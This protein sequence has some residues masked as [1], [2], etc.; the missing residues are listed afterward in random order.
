MATIPRTWIGKDV[1]RLEDPRLL[2][3]R[4]NYSDDVRLPGMAHAAVLRSPQAHARIVR[5]DTSR[6]RALPGVF[7]VITGDDAKELSNPLPA[8]CAEPVV[9][10]ALAVDK[11]RYAGEAVAAVAAVD[12]YTAE[13]AVG[14]IDVDYAPLPVLTDPFEAMKPEAPK[15]HDN[16]PSNLVFEKT[17]SFGDVA[18]GFASADRVIRRR[19]RWH[20]ASAQPLET[21]GAVCR[22]NPASGRMDVWSNTN[23]INYVGWLVAN[24]LKVPASKLNIN[25]MDVGGSFGS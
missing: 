24:T 15:V 12:R 7:A 6:A 8:F 18:G 16:L 4:A 9:Q 1:Q 21:A 17:L 10:Y 3:G 25:P 11:V 2:T 5:I 19:L 13:D 22:Y 20:R 23:M 14:L